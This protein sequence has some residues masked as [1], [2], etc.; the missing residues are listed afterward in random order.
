VVKLGVKKVKRLTI[1]DGGSKNVNQL[2]ER[3]RER[4]RE[5]EE[6]F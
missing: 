1:W 2:Q 6:A 5:R 4:E 3:E